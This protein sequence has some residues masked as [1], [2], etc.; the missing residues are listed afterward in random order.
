[1]T[2]TRSVHAHRAIS[3]ALLATVGTLLTSSVAHAQPADSAVLRDV[4]APGQLTLRLMPARN[5]PQRTGPSSWEF[6]RGYVVTRRTELPGV[7]LRVLSQA[8]YLSSNGR[9][10]RYARSLTTSNSYDGIPAP[11]AQEITA[12]IARDLPAVYR[13][14]V[15]TIVGQPS[16]PTLA[17]EPQF[18]F[19]S[20]IR[21]SFRMVAELDVVTSNTTVE[22]IRMPFDVNM[23]RDRFDSPWVRLNA[24]PNHDAKQ[25]LATRTLDAALVA[26]MTRYAHVMGGQRSRTVEEWVGEGARSDAQAEARRGSPEERA[27]FRVDAQPSAA[28]ATAGIPAPQWQQAIAQVHQQLRSADRSALEAFLRGA[29]APTM[30]T[31][32][33]LTPEGVALVSDA[34][35]EVFS[36]RGNFREQFCGPMTAIPAQSPPN[37]LMLV[38]AVPET[39]ALIQMQQIA[40]LWYVQRLQIRARH[41]DEALRLVQARGRAQLCP[42]G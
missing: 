23:Y 18:E 15:G 27:Q 2:H 1:M 36:S 40:G 37:G 14:M 4:R 28:V 35:F 38:G 21:V 11:S 19:P 13:T 10:W 41:D 24:T 3:T 33:A 20:L 12:L 31:Q 7:T 9:S 30:S 8:M 6:L 25:V 29:L 17:P 32:G 22:R 5:A 26:R 16:A 39:T 34:L 42:S